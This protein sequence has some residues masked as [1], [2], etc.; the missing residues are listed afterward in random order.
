MTKKELTQRINGYKEYLKHEEKVLFDILEY[1]RKDGTPESIAKA[2]SQ[3]LE[4]YYNYKTFLS[5]LNIYTED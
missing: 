4:A 3:W 1:E 5:M 2:H